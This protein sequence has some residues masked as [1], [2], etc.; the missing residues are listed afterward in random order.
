MIYMAKNQ[1]ITQQTKEGN[2]TLFDAFYLSLRPK[3]I[4]WARKHYQKEEQEAIELFQ[5]SMLHTYENILKGKLDDLS[6]KLETYV[7]GIAK[8]IILNL[9]RSLTIQERHRDKLI[10]HYR[11][12]SQYSLDNEDSNQTPLIEL[13]KRVFP[14][15]KTGCQDI[16]KRFYFEEKKA[17][18]IAQELGLNSEQVVRTQKSR[19]L[20]YLKQL[21]AE[22][23][24][25]KN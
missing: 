12:L 8:N 21:V 11:Q 17:Q 24:T 3:F 18:L 10:Q 22:Q 13:V 23:S 7:F 4:H 19:C 16:L 14:Q 1:A 25:Y 2:T 5:Q 15:L 20:K 9:N 6:A